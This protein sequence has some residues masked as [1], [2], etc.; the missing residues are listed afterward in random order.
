[1]KNQAAKAFADNWA[2]EPPIEKPKG[3]SIQDTLLEMANCIA[4]KTNT[5]PM[6]ATP[7]GMDKY[8]KKGASGIPGLDLGRDSFQLKEEVKP[9]GTEISPKKPP[10]VSTLPAKVEGKNQPFPPLASQV[11]PPGAS[12]TT[13]P[14][15]NL[16]KDSKFSPGGPNPGRNNSGPGFSGPGENFKNQQNAPGSGPARAFGRFGKQGSFENYDEFGDETQDMAAMHERFAEDEDANNFRGPGSFQGQNKDFRGPG[17]PPENMRGQ[18]PNGP[19]NNNF[20]GPGGPNNNFRGPGGPNENFRG[21]GGSQDNFRGP[22]PYDNRRGPND[23]RDPG[24]PNDNFRGPGGPNENFRGPGGSNNNFR[25]PGGPPDNS[26]GGPSDNFKGPGGPPDNFR[27][28]GGPPDN[29]RGQGGPPDNF[30][31]QGGPP[32][33]FRGQGGPPDNFRGEG[34]PPD[35]FRGS[36][37]TLEQARGGHGL[38]DNFRGPDNFRG[39]PG[40]DFRGPDPKNQLTPSEQAGSIPNEFN[41]WIDLGSDDELPPELCD[42]GAPNYRGRDGSPMGRGMNWQDGPGFNNDDRRPPFKDDFDRGPMDRGRMP[43]NNFDQRFVEPHTLLK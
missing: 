2:K 32:D 8:P 15:R 5:G 39:G 42:R 11:K 28:P 25:G 35:N 9:P 27:G 40:D 18:G 4:P 1:V 16:A 38:S 14:A 22:G 41:P 7:D 37:E 10:A 43:F 13:G 31:G 6:N 36:G 29:F 20:S 34:G 26:P 19:N 17:G 33:N 21:P 23:F 3:K 24:G 30:R 12:P